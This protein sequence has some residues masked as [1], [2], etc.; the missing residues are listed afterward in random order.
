MYKKALSILCPIKSYYKKKKHYKAIIN[1]YHFQKF[2]MNTKH[3]LMTIS[4]F[5]GHLLKMYLNIKNMVIYIEIDK[6]IK[7]FLTFQHLCTENFPVYNILKKFLK[8]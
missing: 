5:I 6:N 8:E 2:P 1:I 7:I 4:L 3:H